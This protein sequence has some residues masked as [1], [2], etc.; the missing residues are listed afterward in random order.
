MKFNLEMLDSISQSEL[1][2][3]DSSVLEGLQVKLVGLQKKRASLLI[4]F[5]DSDEVKR[6]TLS[7]SLTGL[8][9][10]NKWTA[11]DAVR[12]AIIIISQEGIPFLATKPDMEGGWETI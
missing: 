9:N 10:K 8:V 2:T 7:E 3:Y 6:I 11:K 12:N 4:K 1:E 5:S